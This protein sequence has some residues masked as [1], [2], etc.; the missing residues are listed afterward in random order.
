MKENRTTKNRFRTKSCA[1]DKVDKDGD[2]IV[3]LRR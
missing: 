3:I 1:L 2:S